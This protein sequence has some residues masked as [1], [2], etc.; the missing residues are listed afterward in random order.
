MH[1]AQQD[2]RPGVVV[3]DVV[4][5]VVEVDAE[6]DLRGLVGD[7]VDAAHRIGDGGGIAHVARAPLRPGIVDG[8]GL[9]EV[10]DAHL[11]ARVEQRL[12]DVGAD[13]AGAAGDEDA[14]RRRP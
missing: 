13:E 12:D 2:R 10:E 4:G 5:H 14:H 7:R 6:A 9:P 11:R 8:A 1:G 3:V